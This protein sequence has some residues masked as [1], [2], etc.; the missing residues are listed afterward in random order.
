MWQDN[1]KRVTPYVPG[2]QPQDVENLI[3]LNTNENPYPPA[4]GVIRALQE[5]DYEALRL[6]PD[7][8]ARK[9]RETIAR[10]HGISPLQVFVGVGSD[11]VLSTAFLACFHGTEPVRFPDIT[12]SFYP[13]WCAVY[14]IP[15][16][17]VPLNAD[18]GICASD[19][20][21]ACGGIVF[22]NPNAPTGIA[23][24]VSEVERIVS[25]HPECVVI[26]D[27]AYVDFGAESAL[28]LVNSYDNLLIVRTMSKSRSL[29]G[30]RVG[31][32]I[33][34]E[35]LIQAIC[36]VRNSINSYTLNL[37]SQMAAVASIEDEQYF[38]KQ[39]RSII[40]T[41]NNI[42]KRLA[43]MGF[44]VTDS[45]ANFLFARHPQVSGIHIY[46]RLRNEGIYVR[47]WERPARI[48]DWLRITIGTD[49]Q[50]D[51]LIEVME[52]II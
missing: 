9:L 22:P 13:V 15:Y 6:Y 12:Y 21:G 5:A 8:D 41:R 24:S 44:E 50:M 18:F 26:C 31:Y 19:Y 46:N 17:Q 34:S 28:G 32:A 30:L 25:A 37:P 42:R 43:G 10:Y 52:S 3:K 4:P 2:E 1:L 33:G 39:V 11:D 14:G 7:P 35:P 16:R 20:E 45:K 27:E 48:S 38:T 23:L 36:S 29:A 49:A 40:F 51:R 47:R